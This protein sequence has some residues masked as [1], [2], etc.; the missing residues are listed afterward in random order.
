MLFC[1]SSASAPR[2]TTTR[3]STGTLD[4]A[5][6]ADP[7]IDGQYHHASNPSTTATNSS[8]P[9]APRCRRTERS[10]NERPVFSMAAFLY[11]LCVAWL[12]RVIPTEAGG[13]IV[14]PGSNEAG[15]PWH[16]SC[17]RNQPGKRDENFDCIDDAAPRAY[18][19]R[20]GAALPTDAAGRDRRAQRAGRRLRS[21]GA[22][23]EH[24]PRERKTASGSHAGD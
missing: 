7:C 22:A 18:G 20:V 19:R 21:P 6:G 2:A 14:A 23:Y 9:A 3:G 4:D 11:P 1:S 17:W 10:S 5:P 8:P 13:A 15:A 12:H 16:N 24:A